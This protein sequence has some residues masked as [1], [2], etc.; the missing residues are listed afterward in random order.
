M[1]I[2]YVVGCK[3]LVLTF[4]KIMKIVCKY[5]GI[6]DGNVNPNYGCGAKIT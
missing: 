4:Q 1:G 3:G 2:I 6:L 5:I